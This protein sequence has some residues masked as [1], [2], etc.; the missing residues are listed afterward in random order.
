LKRK[1]LKARVVVEEEKLFA[2]K[3]VHKTRLI[4]SKKSEGVKQG[5]SLTN[6]RGPQKKLFEKA[7]APSVL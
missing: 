7:G 6:K 3:K 5:R 2:V 4:K 1:W